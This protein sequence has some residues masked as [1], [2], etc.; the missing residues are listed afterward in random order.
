ML[1]YWR[2]H[3]ILDMDM[4]D[5]NSGHLQWRTTIIR[6]G[7]YP[8]LHPCTSQLTTVSR[9]ISGFVLNFAMIFKS[10]F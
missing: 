3:V 8:N 2:V 1:I 7:V 6:I 10:T 5:V 9:Q 4:S